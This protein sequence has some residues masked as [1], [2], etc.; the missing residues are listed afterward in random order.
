M[1]ESPFPGMDPYLELDW[2]DVHSALVTYIRDQLQERLPP[3]LCARMESRVLVE[4]E[5]QG[6]TARRHPDVRVVESGWAGRG[7]TAVL[8]QTQVAEFEPDLYLGL[9]RNEP[10]TQ[11]YIEI[12]DAQ[13]RSRV[14]TA[15]ELVSPSNKHRGPGL[16]LYL[17]KRNECIEAGVNLVEIDLTRGDRFLLFPELEG[18][19]PPAHYVACVRR[20]GTGRIGVYF[21][22]LDK[23][24]KPIRIPLRDKDPDA[25][26]D[27][28]PLVKQAYARGRYDRLDYRRPLH[29]PP[30]SEEAELMARFLKAAGVAAT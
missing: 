11:R 2:L 30:R 19:A 3:D 20:P 10:A 17:K 4:D 12:V 1:A 9:A 13:T 29:P 23:P 24:L 18:H 28:Q 7:A 26:L 5:G 8:E 25:V 14:I 15:I 22:P 21:F 27:L 16:D 6:E